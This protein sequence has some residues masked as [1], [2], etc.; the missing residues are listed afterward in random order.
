[1]ERDHLKETKKK[2]FLKCV[3]IAS[4]TT[5]MTENLILYCTSIMRILYFV[6]K[7]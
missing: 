6:L 1:M 7:N 4:F 2:L 3:I 5:R